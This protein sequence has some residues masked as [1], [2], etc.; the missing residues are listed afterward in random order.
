MTGVVVWGII[1]WCL[2]DRDGSMGNNEVF[3]CENNRNEVNN[4]DM[5][6]FE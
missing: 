4:S 6:W 3:Y 2:S 5:F 1:K